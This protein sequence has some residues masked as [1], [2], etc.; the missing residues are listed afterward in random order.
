MSKRVPTTVSPG[1]S[2]AGARARQIHH[3]AADDADPP[4]AA[5]HVGS[6]GSV[7]VR[8]AQAL[9]QSAR[10]VVHVEVV[11]TEAPGHHEGDGQRI[12]DHGGH[13]G[14]GRRDEV[15]WV[16]FGLDADVDGGVGQI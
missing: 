14:G 3:E 11:G 1:S 5:A 8:S 10:R 16:G 15:P 12:A 7:A 4:G 6:T 2:V 13:R 9:A